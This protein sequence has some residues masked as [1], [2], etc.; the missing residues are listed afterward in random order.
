MKDDSVFIRHILD[1]MNYII[2]KTKFIGYEDFVDDE[3]LT[4]AITRSLEIIGEATK[5]LSIN[6][7][8]KHPDIEWRALTGLRD[9]LIHNYWGVNFE[10]VWD[11]IE[12][13]IP[14]IERKLKRILENDRK[15]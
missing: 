14:E 1:E 12:N 3:T 15:L 11:I 5:N 2:R 13:L 7:R 9:K 8:E 4:K 10:R 6:F